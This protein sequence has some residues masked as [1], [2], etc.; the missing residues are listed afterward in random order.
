[1]AKRVNDT[2]DDMQSGGS[3][4]NVGSI[5]LQLNLKMNADVLIAQALANL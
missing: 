4:S 2:G 3:L 1:M 5:E